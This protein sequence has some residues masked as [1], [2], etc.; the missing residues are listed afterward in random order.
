VPIPQ[1]ELPRF[2]FGENQKAGVGQ[3]P[4]EKGEALDGEGR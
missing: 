1:I 4:G 3:G 2:R